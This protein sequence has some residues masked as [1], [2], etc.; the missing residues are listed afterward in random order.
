MFVS[1][2]SAGDDYCQAME[3]ERGRRPRKM[4]QAIL[5]GLHL[6]GA[7]GA[8]SFFFFLPIYCN[9]SLVINLHFPFISK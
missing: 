4:S 2:R 1:F 7:F 8:I 3:S 6:E 5:K 9:F